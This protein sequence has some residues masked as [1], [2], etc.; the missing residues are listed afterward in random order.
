MISAEAKREIS[1]LNRRRYEQ[2]RAAGQEATPKGLPEATVLNSMP[3]AQE[4]VIHSEQVPADWYTTMRLRRGETVPALLP[5]RLA[6]L[7]LGVGDHLRRP[8]SAL[9]CSAPHS[10][11]DCRTR[12]C[13]CADHHGIGA[14]RVFGSDGRTTNSLAQTTNSNVEERTSASV[15]SAIAPRRCFSIASRKGRAPKRG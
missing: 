15:A 1:E 14:D 8:R 11:A 9:G 4:A 6:S 2:L 5:H 10:H 13:G 7:P 3:I 12:H